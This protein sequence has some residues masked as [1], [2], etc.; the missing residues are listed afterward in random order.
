MK[1]F[2]RFLIS[3]PESPEVGDVVF[4]YLKGRVELFTNNGWLDLCPLTTEMR[5]VLEGGGGESEKLEEI[6]N[7]FG[8]H[9]S[10]NLDM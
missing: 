8:K 7:L 1:I 5:Q 6:K 2:S 10:R 9:K 4:S 3:K